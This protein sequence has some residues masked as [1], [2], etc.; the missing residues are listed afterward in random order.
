MSKQSRLNFTRSAAPAAPAKKRRRLSTG[1]DENEE[2]SEPSNKSLRPQRKTK[3][4]S[5]AKAK[6]P[7]ATTTSRQS[8][9]TANKKANTT[10]SSKHHQDDAEKISENSEPQPTPSAA[11]NSKPP[12]KGSE[13]T[14]ATTAR[15]KVTSS[16]TDL[17]ASPPNTVICHATNAQGTWG[18]GIAA[19]FRTKYPQAFT[20][21]AAHCKKW[22]SSTLLGTTL[23]IPPQTS[24]SNRSE[25]E[26]QHW[27]G[28]LFTSEKK[29]KG[30][31]S[32]ES[33]LEATGEAVGDLARKVAGE[34]EIQGVRMCK[35]NS[36]LFGVE[37]EASKA[38]IEGIEVEEEAEG[39]VLREIMV[40]SLD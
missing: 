35:I 1:E 34:S 37:W 40:C 13:V 36:G 38:V 9:S 24:S 12:P 10:S 8:N 17:F 32:K 14:N 23:L 29:G 2:Q 22:P 39:S 28:C 6:T 33:I 18:A 21:Y 4:S 7:S 27:I 11:N 30:K 16:R 19:A 5:S 3:T 15:I 31:G 25:R 20:L 26:A